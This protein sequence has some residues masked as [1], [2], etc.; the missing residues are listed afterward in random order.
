MAV[1]RRAWPDAPSVLAWSPGIEGSERDPKGTQGEPGRDAGVTKGSLGLRLVAEAGAPKSRQR[2]FEGGVP[3][4]FRDV[5][6]V[7]K[8]AVRKSTGVEFASTDRAAKQCLTVAT[9]KRRANKSTERNLPVPSR[10][11][12]GLPDGSRPASHAT[13]VFSSTTIA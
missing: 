11:K 6:N 4:H 7:P 3:A 5:R 12:I 2:S 1:A 9:T 13:I 8:P 10:Q